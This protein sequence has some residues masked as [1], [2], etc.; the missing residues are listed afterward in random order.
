MY[1][2][3][4]IKNVNAAHLALFKQS[5]EP[6]KSGNP[7]EKLNGI[8][9]SLLPPC[10]TVLIE[11]IKCANFVSVVWKNASK[12]QPE[13]FSPQNSG[14]QSNT[15]SYE[16]SWFDS[17]QIPQD[18]CQHIDD[19]IEAEDDEGDLQYDSSDDESDTDD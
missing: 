16:V 7:L 14:W 15:G 6:G 8:D 5:N 10:D 19:N 17:D 12:A 1:G 4:T 13:Q 2:K 11:Q 3:P 9:S 18:I